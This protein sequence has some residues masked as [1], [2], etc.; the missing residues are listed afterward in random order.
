MKDN[1]SDLEIESAEPVWGLHRLFFVLMA[2][3]LIAGIIGVF[4]NGPASRRIEKDSTGALQ[5]Q[6]DKTIRAKAP[7]E[8][9]IRS[10]A[11]VNADHQIRLSPEFTQ[12]MEINRIVPEPKSMKSERGSLLMTFSN[13]A[14]DELLVHLYAEPERM[15]KFNGMISRPDQSQIP[16][17]QFILP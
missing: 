12:Q 14:S 7:A 1:F 16:I 10:T 4:G 11:P 13:S 8:Y 15:G 3:F 9:Q 17:S 5:V 2:L 6:F